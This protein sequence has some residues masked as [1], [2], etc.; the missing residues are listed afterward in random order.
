MPDVEKHFADIF[1]NE[2]NNVRSDYITSRPDTSQPNNEQISLEKVSK[3]IQRIRVDTAAGPDKILMRV[4]KETNTA[5]VMVHI[6]NIMLS[7]TLVPDCFRVGRMILFLLF[8][9]FF[10]FD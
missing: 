5:K 2:N 9:L 6:I 7:R 10:L 1:E 8:Y 4:V 3:A